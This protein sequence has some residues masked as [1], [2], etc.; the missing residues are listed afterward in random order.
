MAY[1]IVTKEDINQLITEEEEFHLGHLELLMEL[2]L[3]LENEGTLFR[4]VKSDKWFLVEKNQPI[5]EHMKDE[6]LG[7]A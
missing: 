5:P 3:M 2:K 7:R 6:I 4:E 1:T